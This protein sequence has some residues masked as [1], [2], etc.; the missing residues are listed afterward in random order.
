MKTKETRTQKRAR[1]TRKK[2]KK[3][4]LDVFTE[5][6]VAAA[7]V[8]EITEKA[9]VGKG[10]LYQHFADK[11]Q[12]VV[13]LVDEAV[14]H[15]IGRFRAYDCKPETLE[16]MLQH[17]L[18]AHY[19]FSVE[20]R[21]EFLLLFQG[22]LLLKLESDTMD[23][24]E[25]PYLRYLQEIEHQVA[26]YL[27]PRIDTVKIRR[28][29]CAVA[30]FVFGFFSFAMIGMTEKEIEASVNPLRR[31]FVRSLCAFLGR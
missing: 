15:L 11:D 31:V 18:N 5:K 25:E 1:R 21:E 20:C 19:D 26:P 22:K 9:D 16:D 12:I 2:L 3:A 28:L 8:E 27:S 7:T 17:L 4:A 24:L 29:A 10:T 14:D 23:E 30:G 6:S 13:T